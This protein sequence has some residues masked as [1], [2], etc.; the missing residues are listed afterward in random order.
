L[1]LIAGVAF[2][3]AYLLTH[4]L[5]GIPAI[6][7]S[8]SIFGTIYVMLFIW[9]KISPDVQQIWHTILNRFS[10]NKANQTPN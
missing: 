9:R 8:L 1:I 2:G 7:A 10:K 6:I 4:S 5:Q 3:T